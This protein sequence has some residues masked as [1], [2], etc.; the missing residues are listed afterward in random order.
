MYSRY[1][2]RRRLDRRRIL[3]ANAASTADTRRSSAASSATGRTRSS[4]SSPACTACNGCRRPKRRA[5]CTRPPAPSPCCPSRRTSARSRSIRRTSRRHV[6]RVRRGRPAREQDG[7]GDPDHAPPDRSRRRVPGRALAAQEPRARDVA[8][9]ARLRDAEETKRASETAQNR[10]AL[11]GTG[12]RSERIR[13]YNFPQDRVTDHRINLTIYKL[14]DVLQGQ[15]R[16]RD[17]AARQRAS[18]RSARRARRQRMSAR[19]TS[20]IAGR[21]RPYGICCAAA[22]ATLAAASRHAASR[23]RAV[24]RVCDGAPRDAARASSTNDR[25]DGAAITIVGSLR[26]ARAASRLRTSP[27]R[28]SSTRCRSR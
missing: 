17:R 16:R 13:T 21:P 18:R 15:S 20:A 3:S 26:G 23:R 11:V 19:A 6:P 5:A 4:S 1:A 9:P 2:E 24:A 10:R 12:D 25:R 28:R 27:A 7:F 8:P 14:G 22:A